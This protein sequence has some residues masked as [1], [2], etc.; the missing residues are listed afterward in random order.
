MSGLDSYVQLDTVWDQL[1]Q[2]WEIL[3]SRCN[4]SAKSQ[5]E[6]RTLKPLEKTTK[7]KNSTSVTAQLKLRGKCFCKWKSRETI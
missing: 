6:L 3:D 7:L 1:K 4:T 2:L 5:Y